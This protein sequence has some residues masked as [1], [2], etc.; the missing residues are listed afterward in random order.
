MQIS[1]TL[2]L[3]VSFLTVVSSAVI[4]SVKRGSFLPHVRYIGPGTTFYAPGVID[5][6]HISANGALETEYKL[7]K[8][9]IE[10][11]IQDLKN[12]YTSKS[13]HASMTKISKV[14]FH[15]GDGPDSVV[16]KY[17]EFPQ[18]DG[19]NN[20]TVPSDLPFYTLGLRFIQAEAYTTAAGKVSYR[21]F[22]TTEI[23][24][25]ISD[26]FVRACGDQM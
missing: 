3:G 12:D 4:G 7:T 10:H 11:A 18:F 9:D 21:F 16:V 17:L 23:W 14:T 15:P 19:R 20:D 25:M 24:L 1:T 2:T 22:R 26:W 5:C 13:W 8:D 6:T